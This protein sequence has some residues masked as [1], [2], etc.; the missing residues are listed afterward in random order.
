MLPQENLGPVYD[1]AL[2]GLGSWMPIEL[3]KRCSKCGEIRGL[4]EFH[5]CKTNRDG[6]QGAC[7]E[8]WRKDVRKNSRRRRLEKKIRMLSDPSVIA[9]KEEEGRN[10]AAGLKKCKKCCETKGLEGFYSCE[11]N[12]DGRYGTCIKCHNEH[13]REVSRSPEVKIL[14]KE[15]RKRPEVQARRAVYM[16]EYRQTPEAK[17]R[18]KE[19]RGKPEIK[20]QE[21]EYSQRSEVRAR[22]NKRSKER[23][24]TDLNF[25]IAQNLRHRMWGAIKGEIKAGSAVKDLGC[26]IDEFRVYL[27]KQ[28]NPGM[29]WGNYGNGPGKWNLDHIIPLT[30]FDLTNRE[31]YLSAAHY[32][33]YQ[34]MWAL[35]NTS[36]GNRY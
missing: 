18:K 11:R 1:K 25:R 19:C 2:E 26:F 12:F 32:A 27:E 29:T 15:Y 14:A 35:E 10:R 31:Q 4:G 34:P 33:N 22:A 24:A 30:V 20:A 16:K 7:K 9:E 6:R 13:R 36:K 17:A 8:C 5:P 3:V 28:F 21:K 23:W